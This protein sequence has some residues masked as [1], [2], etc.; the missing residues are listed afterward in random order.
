MRVRRPAASRSSTTTPAR[1]A[2]ALVQRLSERLS[3][4][5]NASISDDRLVVS[6]ADRKGGYIST[7]AT[8]TPI[9]L[10]R[11]LSLAIQHWTVI[12]TREG[13]LV[14]STQGYLYQVIVGSDAVIEFHYHPA[15][16]ADHCHVHVAGALPGF[17]LNKIHIPTGRIAI[18]DVILLVVND[19]DVKPKRG[20]QKALAAERNWFETNQTWGGAR[21]S[22]I[23]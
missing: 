17:D 8:A 19:F 1:S 20:W 3:R 10:T 15:Q 22:P 13:K 6:N 4:S 9:K 14:T 21:R 12:R 7:D 2:R 11:S 18:E 5:L 23:R 16:R